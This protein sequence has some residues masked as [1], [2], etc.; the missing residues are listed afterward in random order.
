MRREKNEREREKWAKVLEW[1]S[2]F[3]R[4]RVSTQS[5]PDAARVEK[6]GKPKKEEKKKNLLLLSPKAENIFDSSFKR[7]FCPDFLVL[8]STMQSTIS[9]PLLPAGPRFLVAVPIQAVWNCK[10]WFFFFL[11]SMTAKTSYNKW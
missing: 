5:G 9:Q 1:A 3:V 2:H 10:V 8:P 6:G 7:A 11:K 4:M